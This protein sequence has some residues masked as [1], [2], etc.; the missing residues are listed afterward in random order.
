MV[1]KKKPAKKSAPRKNPKPRRRRPKVKK[2][3]ARVGRPTKYDPSFCAM[4]RAMAALGATDREIAHGLR[5]TEQTCNNWKLAHP[6]FFESLRVAKEPANER[7][8]ASLYRRA[9]GYSFDAEKIMVIEGKVTRVKYVEH[10]PPDPT[11]LKFWMIN[12]DKENWR[13]Q[14][15]T[16][17]TTPPGQPI[18]QVH[19]YVPGSPQLLADYYAR[20]AR[21]S[22]E[23][24]DTGLAGNMGRGRSEGDG[25]DGDPD[26]VPDGPILSPR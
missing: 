17:L 20:L 26:P 9:H 10:V 4:A 3:P 15:T 13:E 14:K 25:P 5:I 21:A 2:K 8:K 22:A 1:G 16:E 12:R 24:P 23:A 6:E 7:I 19:T 11:C 18:E